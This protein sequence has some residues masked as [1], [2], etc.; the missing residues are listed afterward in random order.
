MPC[1]DVLACLGRSK[2]STEYKSLIQAAV[3]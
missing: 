1:R 2:H 3:Q